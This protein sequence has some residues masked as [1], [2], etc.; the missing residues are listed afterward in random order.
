MVRKVALDEVGPLDEGYFLHCEDLDW[1]VRFARAGWGIYLVP[2]AE[3]V[4]Y[5]GACSLS[6]PVRVEW[7]KHRGMARFFRK[8]QFR[9]YPLPFSLLVLAGIWVH[10]GIAALLNGLRQRVQRFGVGGTRQ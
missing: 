5:K 3:V 1:F 8:F 7:H 9:D 10:F 6:R 4:H 2:D